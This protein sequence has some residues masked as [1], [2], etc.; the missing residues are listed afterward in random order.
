[1]STKLDAL[2]PDCLCARIRPVEALSSKGVADA[3]PGVTYFKSCAAPWLQRLEETR[4]I[5]P[6]FGAHLNGGFLSHVAG[7][8]FVRTR[9]PG[10]K[11][12]IHN[13]VQNGRDNPGE[14]NLPGTELLHMHAPS[15]AAWKRH[16]TY[17][18]RQ[19]SY[20]AELAPPTQPPGAPVTDPLALN[21]NT[22]FATL[23]REKG[24]LRSFYDEVCLATPGLR[25]RLAAHGHLRAHRLDLDATRRR[26]FG[27]GDG[28]P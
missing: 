21:L 24:G 18:M 12:Q 28:G 27:P 4:A 25:A 15:F 6:T 1:L 10:M 16:L 5:Y 14:V 26:I 23:G 19:G 7:K 17:R 11:V 9:Q 2:T 13:V 3:D 22:L 20:R 8:L